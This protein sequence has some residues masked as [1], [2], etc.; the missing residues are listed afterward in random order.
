MDE[1]VKVHGDVAKVRFHVEDILDFLKQ[2]SGQRFSVSR[3]AEGLNVTNLGR[4]SG[5]LECLSYFGKVK[6]D[7]LNRLYYVEKIENL[8]ENAHVG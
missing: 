3:I 2:K 7:A 5:I 8:P 1:G 6:F 4:V